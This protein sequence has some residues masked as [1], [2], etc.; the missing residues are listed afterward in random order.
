[1]IPKNGRRFSEK[2]MR[3]QRIAVGDQTGVLF[4]GARAW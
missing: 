3:P 1:M 2:I 4:D